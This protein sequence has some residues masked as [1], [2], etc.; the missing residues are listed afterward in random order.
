MS[1]NAASTPAEKPAAKPAA[2]KPATGSTQP[3][4]L[5]R[6]K[7]EAIKTPYR[8]P[9]SRMTVAWHHLGEAFTATGIHA[10]KAVVDF[11]EHVLEE[12]KGLSL[13]TPKPAAK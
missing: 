2:D 6:A 13:E 12:A 10:G 1:E 4:V 8:H 5:D 11:V 9:K 7:A 3:P